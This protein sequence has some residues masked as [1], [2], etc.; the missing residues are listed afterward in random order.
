[1]GSPALHHDVR[2]PEIDWS[3]RPLLFLRCRRGRVHRASPSRPADGGRAFVGLAL[4]DRLIAGVSWKKRF[5]RTWLI[6]A[7]WFFPTMLWM[8]DLTPPGYVVACISYA[9]YFGAAVACVPPGRARWIGLPGAVV[10]ATLANV[11]LPVRWRALGQPR[12]HPGQLVRPSVHPARAPLAQAA[13]LAGPL[14]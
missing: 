7:T 9:A 6:C 8:F 13:R 4:W 12:P 1:M 10:L 11:D 3:T 14:P 2:L 5:R